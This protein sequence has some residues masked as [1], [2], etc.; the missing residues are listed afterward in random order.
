MNLRPFKSQAFGWCTYYL[1]ESRALKATIHLMLTCIS[2]TWNQACLM[3]FYYLYVQSNQTSPSLLRMHIYKSSQIAK[4]FYHALSYVI[5]C[6][7]VQSFTSKFWLQLGRAWDRWDVRSR[8]YECKARRQ[9]WASM[10]NFLPH[11][12]GEW[13][14][15]KFQTSLASWAS[16]SRVS[17]LF[18]SPDFLKIC[19][20]PRVVWWKRLVNLREYIQG[21]QRRIVLH[22]IIFKG[23]NWEQKNRFPLLSNRGRT[24]GGI[25]CWLCHVSDFLSQLLIAECNPLYE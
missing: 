23:I 11:P 4:M 22:S 16:W 20:E 21:S 6:T 7:P 15:I 12:D 18:G 17:P 25:P 14:D 24:R 13:L 19:D 8:V 5:W 2:I 3:L 9:C 10:T 1:K